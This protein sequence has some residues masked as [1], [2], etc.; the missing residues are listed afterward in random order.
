MGAKSVQVLAHVVLVMALVGW[1]S[2]A[3]EIG[4]SVNS[5]PSSDGTIG[6]TSCDHR[7]TKSSDSGSGLS[8]KFEMT[9]VV[10]KD[11]GKLWPRFETLRLNI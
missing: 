2:I 11:S 3:G 10:R 4:S 9:R 7:R 1:S 8:Q 6:G 5:A